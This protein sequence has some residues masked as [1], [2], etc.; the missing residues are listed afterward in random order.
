MTD[1]V[2]ISAR[3]VAK[4]QRHPQFLAQIRSATHCQQ[5][6]KQTS[7]GRSTNLKNQDNDSQ[8]RPGTEKDAPLSAKNMEQRIA[9][10]K[11]TSQKT[12]NHAWPTPELDP[13][14][15]FGNT[16]FQGQAHTALRKEQL[17]LS[18]SRKMEPNLTATN[19]YLSCYRFGQKGPHARQRS[20]PLSNL[21]SEKQSLV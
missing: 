16:P 2:R 13:S 4:N 7:T 6:E 20:K 17:I 19:T 11:H 21:L 14:E 3:C 5:R 12:G 8:Q 1:K 9:S 10:K 18:K 15:L